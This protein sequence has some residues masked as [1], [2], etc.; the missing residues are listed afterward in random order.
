M[1]L[2][3]HDALTALAQLWMTDNLGDNH[4]EVRAE[5]VPLMNI[6][7]FMICI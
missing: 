4:N 3:L 5:S 1:K 6:L 7:W 2:A